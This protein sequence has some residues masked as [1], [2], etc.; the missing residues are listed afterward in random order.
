MKKVFVFALAAFLIFTGGFALA[1]ELGNPAKLIKKGQIDV[2]VEGV[3]N[4]KQSFSN[5][6]L[7]RSF[8]NGTSDSS[9]VGADFEDDAFYM[10]TITYG[11]FDRLNL[12]ARL[13]LADGGEW[14]D[15][16]AGNNWK[17]NLESNFVWALGAKFDALTLDNGFGVIMAGQYTRYDNR[18]VDEWTSQQTGQSAG[19]LGWN[20]N[21]TIDFW[22]ADF[23][24]TTYWTF[25]AFTPYVGAGY[26]YYKVNYDG[27]WTHSDPRVGWIKYDSSFQNS[28]N[29]TGLVGFD[30]DLGEHFKINAQ[31]SFVS[32]TA[33]SL[34]LS[35]CF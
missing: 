32:R 29:F 2:G 10:A 6:R 7:N 35:Y 33:V 14:K 9:R 3:Y 16:Q 13:G 15:Y 25:G 31:G 21:D 27:E 18:K 30:I 1:Q 24:V 19:Q 5:Y 11:L 12:F 28:D 22:Q 23:V 26:S 34:G 8:S 4:V 20:T 17:A